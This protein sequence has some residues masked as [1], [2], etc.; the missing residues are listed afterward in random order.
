MTTA[1][2][3]IRHTTLARHIARQLKTVNPDLY[4]ELADK[5]LTALGGELK[6]PKVRVPKVKAEKAPKAV[7]VVAPEKLK[8][9]ELKALLRGKAP[10]KPTAKETSD[11]LRTQGVI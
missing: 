11:A 6:Q 2:K 10:K 5:A 4:N 9:E 7:K 8:K 3:I 1:T